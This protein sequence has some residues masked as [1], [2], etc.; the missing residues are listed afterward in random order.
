[1]QSNLLATIKSASFLSDDGT[2][3]WSPSIRLAHHST[4]ALVRRAL[5]MAVDRDAVIQNA[6]QGHGVPSTGP[7]W[8]KNWAYNASIASY[9]FDPAL[10]GTLL[11]SA[12]FTGRYKAR[13][14]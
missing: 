8:P 10:A 14:P 5:N 4:T 6:L 12:G 3:T 1:M 9:R 13:W 7:L 2:N 11:N